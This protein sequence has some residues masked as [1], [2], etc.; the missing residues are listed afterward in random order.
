MVVD[1]SKYFTDSVCDNLSSALKIL[2]TIYLV[3]SFVG[4]LLLEPPT[5]DEFNQVKLDI[6]KKS[7]IQE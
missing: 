3:T 7:M 4:C 6:K 2:G 1:G 5:E